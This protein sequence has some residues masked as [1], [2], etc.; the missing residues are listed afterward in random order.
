MSIF[1]KLQEILS[2]Q[3]DT[4]TRTTGGTSAGKADG[5]GTSAKAGKKNK[6]RQ[7]A[8]RKKVTQTAPVQKDQQKKAPKQTKSRTGTGKQKKVAPAAGPGKRQKQKTPGRSPKTVTGGT[9]SSAK[10]GKTTPR[11]RSAAPVN[12]R[13]TAN[14]KAAA[15]KP[16]KKK[17]KSV[18]S[19]NRHG[20]P[21]FQE[22][23]DFTDY[24][25]DDGKAE[26]VV[27]L[28]E[29]RAKVAPTPPEPSKQRK[30]FR[31]PMNRHGIPLFGED[32]DFSFYFRQSA[33]NTGRDSQE[34]QD[35]PTDDE[36]M[37]PDED[38]ETLLEE[39]LAG[40]TTEALLQAK[41]DALPRNRPPTVRQLLK[42][43]PLPQ[44][45]LDLH[46]KTSQEAVAET[47]EFIRK[48]RY[49]GKRT[50]L[51]IVGKGLHS[52]G[53]PILPDVVET[54]ILDLKERQWVLAYEWEK[55]RKRKSGAMVVYLK[56]V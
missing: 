21:V 40:K 50:V 23:T 16:E 25:R 4:R 9:K 44:E 36:A 20:L 32:T 47:E 34:W 33:G 56:M 14:Q 15:P 51:V 39:S 13:K 53:R 7:K 37:E 38:F 52:D 54:R 24:F 29:N 8:S 18:S 22:E 26:P 35:I 49:K 19:V 41:T 48:A 5:T 42:T 45:E 43:Y 3:K 30:K 1:E 55:G 6:N 17:T 46:G 10:P 12:N 27:P 31:R 28:P 11:V 2:T